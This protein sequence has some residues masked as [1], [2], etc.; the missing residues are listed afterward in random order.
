MAGMYAERGLYKLQKMIRDGFRYILE[1]M[2]EAV[3][4]MIDVLRTFFLIVLAILG[5]LAFGIAVYDGFQSTLTGWLCR[6]IQ[7]YLWLPIADLFSCILARIQELSIAHDIEQM[8]TD[9]GFSLDTSDG[10]YLIVMIIGI[11]GYFCVPTVAGWVIQAGGISNYGRNVN[12]SITKSG[13]ALKS[14]ALWLAK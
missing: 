5:P 9:P 7:V 3:S 12:K 10:V 11:I 4:L 1:L 14:G 13:G 2:F 8:Q 6:Y